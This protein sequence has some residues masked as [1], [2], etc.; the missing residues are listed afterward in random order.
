MSSDRLL[1]IQEVIVVVLS[2]I[3][4]TEARDRTARHLQDRFGAPAYQALAIYNMLMAEGR[5]G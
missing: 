1:L 5:I 2:C 4:D 3:K